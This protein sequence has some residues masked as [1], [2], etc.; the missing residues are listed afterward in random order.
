[1][2]GRMQRS[3]KK[4]L[5]EHRW[6]NWVW[7]RVRHVAGERF[8]S[9]IGKGNLRRRAEGSGLR[10]SS[11]G[12]F[13]PGT[14]RSSPTEYRT[15]NIPGCLTNT[16][17]YLGSR[18][19]C[20]DIRFRSALGRRCSLESG[21]FLNPPLKNYPG[22]LRSWREWATARLREARDRRRE[23]GVFSSAHLAVWVSWVSGLSSQLP[24]LGGSRYCQGC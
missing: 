21:G 2:S 18:V 6:W 23:A 13:G 5:R 12:G 14:G 7:L 3:R 8:Y 11:G 16:A 4:V 24:R 15:P 20:R 22:P 1:M 9:P 10:I 17:F 19:S